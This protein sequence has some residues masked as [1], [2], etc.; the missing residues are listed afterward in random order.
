MSKLMMYKGNIVDIFNLREEDVDVEIIK[1]GAC[2]INRFL[3]QTEYLYPVASH[4]I[5]GF[6]YLRDYGYTRTEMKQWLIHEAF[7]SYSGVDLPSPLKALLPEYKKAEQEALY[8]VAKVLGVN[9]PDSEVIKEIDREIMVA[10]ALVLTHNDEYWLN[11]AKE[12][13]IIPLS[14]DYVLPYKT[15]SELKALLDEIFEEVFSI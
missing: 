14:S 7:E 10:E 15:E 2:R 6:Y 1:L 12:E 13:G 11:F 5:G 9:P 3:G 4:L 8:V